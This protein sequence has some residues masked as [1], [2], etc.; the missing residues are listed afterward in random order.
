MQ[1]FGSIQRSLNFTVVLSRP[2]DNEWGVR[3]GQS[4][5]DGTP[6]SWSWTGMVGQLARKEVD[7]CVAGLTIDA[8]RQAVIDFTIGIVQVFFF[9]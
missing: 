1:I 7:V 8:R 4:G 9:F 3:Q 2:P 6:S 5:A